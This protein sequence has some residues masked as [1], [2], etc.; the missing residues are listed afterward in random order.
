MI[1]WLLALGCLPLAWSLSH[2]VTQRRAETLLLALFT[3]LGF[4]VAWLLKVSW[5]A[6]D[7]WPE[8]LPVVVFLAAAVVGGLINSRSASRE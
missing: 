3:W 5:T 2:V 8:W 4:I 7:W 1:G 6:G